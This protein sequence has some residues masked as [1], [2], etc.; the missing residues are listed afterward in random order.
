MSLVLENSTDLTSLGNAVRSKTGGSSLLTVSDM[1]TAVSGI[2]AAGTLTAVNIERTVNTYYKSY[3]FDMSSYL[4]SDNDKDYFLIFWA[5]QT[6]G[7]S[8]NYYKRIIFSPAFPEWLRVLGYNTGT[9]GSSTYPNH[10]FISAGQ[11]DGY[12]SI[13]NSDTV[14]M[15]MGSILAFLKQR[16]FDDSKWTVDYSNHILTLSTTFSNSQPLVAYRAKL[17]YKA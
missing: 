12:L 14:E 2:A 4:N 9:N 17:I 6:I 5:L 8:N 3:S 10:M 16:P 11:L 15:G 1:A 7:G 13:T